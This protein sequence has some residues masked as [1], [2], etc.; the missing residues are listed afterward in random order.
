MTFENLDTLLTERST[1]RRLLKDRIR[2]RVTTQADKLADVET[3]IAELVLQP[4]DLHKRDTPTTWMLVE[5]VAGFAWLST[6]PR[7]AEDS[8]LVWHYCDGQLVPSVP[9]GGW[10]IDVKK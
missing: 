6:D 5:A 1:L 8:S 7:Y 9:T 4:L 2:Y 3:L 10:H